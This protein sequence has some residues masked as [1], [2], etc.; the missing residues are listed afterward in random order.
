MRSAL[1]FL[2]AVTVRTRRTR[3]GKHDYSS[4]DVAAVLGV[5]RRH[6][7]SQKPG[8]LCPSAKTCCRVLCWCCTLPSHTAADMQ[9]TATAARTEIQ[10]R[11]R[12][13]CW[14]HSSISPS[15]TRRARK[16]SPPPPRRR[17]RITPGR[18]RMAAACQERPRRAPALAAVP[19]P[20]RP[21]DAP[22]ARSSCKD[23]G[24]VAVGSQ[25]DP[26][27]TSAPPHGRRGRG[28]HCVWIQGR[29][30]SERLGVDGGIKRAKA[31][32]R[33]LGDASVESCGRAGGLNQAGAVDCCSL[34]CRLIWLTACG[35]WRD[36]G[37]DSRPP[38]AVEPLSRADGSQISSSAL[39]AFVYAPQ[40][41]SPLSETYLLDR[42]PRRELGETSL[43]AR[44]GLHAPAPLRW[45]GGEGVKTKGLGVQRGRR[46][47]GVRVSETTHVGRNL[48]RWHP[49]SWGRLLEDDGESGRWVRPMGLR[50][51]EGRFG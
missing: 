27:Q 4:G 3:S 47:A 21:R 44:A 51:Q 1:L 43:T 50:A 45:R 5:C 31:T 6:L 13:C 17:R 40:S 19:L 2:S 36:E 26:W 24:V 20:P 34:G 32:M 9:K 46:C 29:P 28:Q 25:R 22:A 8:L 48:Q 38:K 11:P 14:P 15:R 39:H 7:E 12:G 49:L 30:R 42:R 18:R 23:A 37:G 10:Q 16:A 35:V 41:S 33:T